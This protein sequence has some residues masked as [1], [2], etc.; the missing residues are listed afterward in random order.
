MMVPQDIQ[1]RL[2]VPLAI[3]TKAEIASFGHHLSQGEKRIVEIGPPLLLGAR[4]AIEFVRRYRGSI[5]L[6]FALLAEQNEVRR[7]CREAAS[8]CLDFVTVQAAGGREMLKAA[9][10][11][12]IEGSADQNN[13][14]RIIGVTLH[15]WIGADQLAQTGVHVVER[16]TLIRQRARLIQECRCHGVLATHEEVSLIHSWYPKLS[17]IATGVEWARSLPPN[18]QGKNKGTIFR[19][20]VDGADAVILKRAPDPSALTDDVQACLAEIEAGLKSR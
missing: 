12:A 1:S 18:F 15:P 19:A 4:A 13:P 7:V 2:I 14:T 20:I 16:E 11:G 17:I 6:N 10:Q 8:L 5:F 3:E 9:V